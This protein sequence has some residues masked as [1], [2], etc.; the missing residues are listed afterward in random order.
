MQDYYDR[1]LRGQYD[2]Y[3]QAQNLVQERLP[4]TL[5]RDSFETGDSKQESLRQLDDVQKQQMV[6]LEYFNQQQ[7]ALHEKLRQ[8][9]ELLALVQRDIETRENLVSNVFQERN[10]QEQQQQEQPI[11]PP[12]A[13]PTI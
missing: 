11:S 3:E 2:G 10:V 5:Q 7:A 4:Q 8:Q 13:L 1:V 12:E 6:E 9:E